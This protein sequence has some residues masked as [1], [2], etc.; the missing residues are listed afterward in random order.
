MTISLFSP[1]HQVSPRA[2]RLY[3]HGSRQEDEAG[4]HTEGGGDAQSRSCHPT[5][6]EHTPAAGVNDE[7]AGLGVAGGDGRTG[8]IFFTF[9]VNCGSFRKFRP[10]LGDEPVRVKTLHSTSIFVQ[11]RRRGRNT[12]S[13]LLYLNHI[14]S[15]SR[16]TSSTRPFLPYVTRSWQILSLRLFCA[17]LTL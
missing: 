15:S 5:P 7:R 6:E 1:R 2:A 3:R 11:V 12:R 10:G 13:A 17:P 16:G 4:P 8:R 9:V 14:S